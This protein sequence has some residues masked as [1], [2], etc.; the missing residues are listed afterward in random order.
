MVFKG[1]ADGVWLAY[2]F[3][4]HCRM[5]AEVRYCE[6]RLAGA[7]LGKRIEY[8]EKRKRQVEPD[9][10]EN[11]ACLTMSATGVGLQCYYDQT[12]CL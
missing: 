12:I 10:N 1:V 2:V 11:T 3:G 7:T 4:K 9:N 6:K 8:K 5:F